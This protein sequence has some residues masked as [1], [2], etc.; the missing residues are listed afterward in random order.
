MPLSRSAKKGWRGFAQGAGSAVLV[1]VLAYF[2]D[3]E[4]VEFLSGKLTGVIGVAALPA[5]VGLAEYVRNLL[6]YGR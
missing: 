3:P 1:A 2:S 6:K 4:V 5:L